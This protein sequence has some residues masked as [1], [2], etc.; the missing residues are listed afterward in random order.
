L[1]VT[2]QQAAEYNTQFVIKIQPD[3]EM[4]ESLLRT[5][6]NKAKS[7]KMLELKTETA[8]SKISLSYDSVSEILESISILKGFK[9]YNHTCY[10]AFLKEILRENELAEEFEELRKIRNDINYH[11]KDVSLAEAKNV[12]ERLESLRGELLKK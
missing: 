6:L 10:T 7:S 12:L 8:A 2:S 5:S 4:A 11:G 1:S 3:T 9:I